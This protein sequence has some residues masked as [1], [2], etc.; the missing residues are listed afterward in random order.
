MVNLA[1]IGPIR[2]SSFISMLPITLQG[3]E[4]H[5]KL[6][7]KTREVLMDAYHGDHLHKEP[8]YVGT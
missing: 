2:I 6:T 5:I 3:V 8:R 7:L 4:E 1:V